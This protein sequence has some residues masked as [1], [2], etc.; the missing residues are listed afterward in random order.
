[1]SF[2]SR[3]CAACSPSSN[4]PTIGGEIRDDAKENYEASAAG[5][6]CFALL[7]LQRFE[8]IQRRIHCFKHPDWTTAFLWPFFC[9]PMFRNCPPKKSLTLVNNRLRVFPHKRNARD[10]QARFLSNH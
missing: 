1:M 6:K 2:S 10:C 8:G 7:L 9:L 3:C 4:F 5:W